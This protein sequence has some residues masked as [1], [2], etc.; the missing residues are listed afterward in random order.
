MNKSFRNILINSTLAFISAFILTTV[1][2][3]LGHYLA[4]VL[5]GADPT[6][7]HNAVQADAQNLG[8]GAKIVVSMGGPVFS[9]IQGMLFASIV[10]KAKRNT[11][12]HLVFLWLALLGLV[13]FFGYLAMTPLSTMGDT[14]KVATLLNFSSSLKLIIA[15]I[16]LLFLMG[17]VLKV[18]KN[19]AHFIPGQ[20]DEEMKTKYVYHL[21][22]FPIIIGS[23]VNVLASF[24]VV[25]L[26]SVIYPATSS[27]AIM[28]SF[29]AILKAPSRYAAGS[30]IESKIMIS[31]LVLAICAVALNRVLTLGL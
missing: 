18:G 16:G 13:N 25:V 1:F 24:P 11:V 12:S 22:F 23:A 4:Y 31:M 3:E 27:F 14:G 19:F 8:L 2:H 17:L 29:P 10:T 21:M 26:L 5:F 30:E 6:L 28:V 7:Y 9:L 15:I 20:A